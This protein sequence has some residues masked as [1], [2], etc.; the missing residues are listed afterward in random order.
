MRLIICFFLF[1]FFSFRTNFSLQRHKETV[2]LK[3]K[4]WACDLCEKSFGEKRDMTR[5]KNAVHFGIKNK[6]VCWKCPE[7][8]IMF[9]LRREYDKHKAAY[10]SLLSDQQIIKFLNSEM[11]SKS[12]KFQINTFVVN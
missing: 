9:K 1:L 8:D 12:Q 6:N 3:L 5:H 11:E 4:A 7:C 2:H 10:H